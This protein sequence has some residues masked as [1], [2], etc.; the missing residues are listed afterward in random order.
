ME[1]IIQVQTLQIYIYMY[2]YMNK[3]ILLY[4]SMYIYKKMMFCFVYILKEIKKPNV[5]ISTWVGILTYTYYYYIV[6]I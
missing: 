2:I 1:Y 3:H 4:V 5:Q 6:F